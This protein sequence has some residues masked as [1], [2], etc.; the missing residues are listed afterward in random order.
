M[1]GK[2]K[3]MFGQKG[4][5]EANA[6][7]APRPRRS[8]VNLQRRYTFVSQTGQGSMSRVHR[9]VDNQTGRVVCIKVQIPDKNAAAAARSAQELRPPEGEISSKIIHPHVVRTFEFGESTR[10]EHFLVM[11]FIDGVSL[12]YIR[13]AHSTT[14]A[15]KLEL[16][17]QAADGLAAVHAHGFIHHDIGPQNFLVDRE[18]QVKLIDFGLAVPNTP[19]FR[20]PGNRTG[21]LNYMAP[22]LVRREPTDERIDIFSF[23]AMAFELLTDKLPYDSGANSMAMLLQRINSD[24]LDPARVNPLLPGELCD[25]VRKLIARR[26]EDR[27]ATMST[28]AEALRGIPVP[29]GR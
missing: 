22:E 11:E 25:V 24:P 6:P 13:E 20:R 9:A 10:G 27:W 26:K 23:G 1:L 17:A 16:L 2:L 28:V 12:K 8:R 15:E 21:T 14:L 4:P 19:A 3:G 29:S 7:G 5:G 18:Q